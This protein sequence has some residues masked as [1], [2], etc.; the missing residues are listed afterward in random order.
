M[1]VVAGLREIKVFDITADF[2]AKKCGNIRQLV[3]LLTAL[4]FFSSM[5]ITNDVA[6]LTFVPLAISVLSLS[7]GE[8]CIIYTV[9]MQT[10]AANMGSMLTPMGNPQNLYLADFYSMSMSEFFSATIPVCLISGVLIFIM[11]LPVKRDKIKCELKPDGSELNKR[12]LAIYAVLGILAIL[13][14]FNVINYVLLTAIT[15]VCVLIFDRHSLKK[16][17]WFLLLTFIMFFVFV[18][19]CARIEA[20]K[21]FLGGLTKGREILVGALASQ[22]ISNVPAAVMLSAF[23]DKGRALMLGVDIGGL[24]TPVASLASL[25]SYRIY[26][27]TPNS[28]R[29]KYMLYFLIINF[30]LLAVIFLLTKMLIRV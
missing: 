20:V 12:L 28:Q 16:L 18:G 26:A 24:G 23:T 14:V 11:L 21:A 4:C 30:A 9:I 8:D 5:V 25:I 3:I 6:L 17:D 22:L 2:F 1:A 7:G 19:N 15:F 27:N 29:G 13:A 10:V